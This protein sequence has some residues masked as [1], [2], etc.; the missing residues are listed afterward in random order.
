[1]RRGEARPE[2]PRGRQ[3]LPGVEEDSILTFSFPSSSCL[4]SWGI[5]KHLAINLQDSGIFFLPGSFLLSASCFTIPENL[6]SQ[7]ASPSSLPLPPPP[8]LGPTF[9]FLSHFPGPNCLLPQIFW[10]LGQVGSGPGCGG[11]NPGWQAV[12]A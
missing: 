10:F 11:Q 8:R 1:M 9:S 5:S 2:G 12:W 3:D 6:S 7:R 4:T